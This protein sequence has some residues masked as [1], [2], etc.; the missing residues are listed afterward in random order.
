MSIALIIFSIF[1][2]TAEANTS[3]PPNALN[4]LIYEKSIN[5]ENIMVV[6]TIADANCLPIVDN[7][8]PSLD[9]YWLM[10]RTMYK[11]L[12][13]IIKSYTRERISAAPSDE[14]KNIFFVNLNDL[15]EIDIDLPSHQVIVE[16]FRNSDGKCEAV[17]KMKLGESDAGATII[18]QKI[19]VDAKQTLNPRRPK[20]KS[21]TL[22]GLDA[23]TGGARVRTY[24]AN[25]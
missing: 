2:V 21:I 25:Q 5:R 15:S 22:E 10:N 4:I 16:T 6:H 3:A 24:K 19:Y 23:S 8:I 12:H 7:Q 1:L 9:Y 13:P 14:A 17:A 11:P 20:I 18:L